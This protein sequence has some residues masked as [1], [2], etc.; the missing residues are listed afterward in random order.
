MMNLSIE[1]TIVKYAD[2]LGQN[3]F[4]F[5]KRVY[6]TNPEIYTNRLKMIGFENQTHVLDA[7]CGFGQWSVCLSKLNSTVTST[8]ISSSRVIIADDIA[9]SMGIKNIHFKQS[10][11]I[12]LPL[13]KNC[14]D[15]V[16]SYG[17][18][19]LVN[20]KQA[21]IEFNRVLKKGGRVYFNTNGLGWALNLWFNQPNKTNDYNPRESV[22]RSFNNTL[23]I[24]NG[25][26]KE[27]GQQISEKKKILKWI[28]ETGFKMI[29]CD[30]DGLINI[31]NS[32]YNSTSFFQKEYF[33]F[34]GVTEYLIEK[35]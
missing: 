17:V 26:G 8:D 3:D 16:F 30:G 29:N 9:T 11:L 22:V 31:T 28:E 32:A 10:E 1:K 19:F 18:I 13:E 4:E 24:D 20:I 15:A 5:L 35:L 6:Q 25:N 27:A 33:G 12:S 2:K 23:L 21:L 34:E 7:G 14:V